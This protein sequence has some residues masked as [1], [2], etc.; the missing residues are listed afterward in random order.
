MNRPTVVRKRRRLALLTALLGLV[1]AVSFA[2]YFETDPT[3]RPALTAG[4]MALLFCPG[5]L[6][7]VTFIDAEPQTSAFLLV[8][9]VVGLINVGLY[10][11]IGAIAGKF[12]WNWTDDSPQD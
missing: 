6:L 11:V 5:S 2:A 9:L 10:G 7:F 1:V 8:W 4:A 3:G 12:L